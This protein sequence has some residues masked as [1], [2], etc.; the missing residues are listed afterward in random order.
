M[1]GQQYVARTT[2]GTAQ[3]GLFFSFVTGPTYARDKG[4][5]VVMKGLNQYSV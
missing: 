5:E 1:Q 2:H 4:P 3:Y